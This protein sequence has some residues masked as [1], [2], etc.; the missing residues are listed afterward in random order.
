[1]HTFLTVETVVTVVHDLNSGELG[2]RVGAPFATE[3]TSLQ[4]NSGPYSRPV[5]D[6]KLLNIKN[7]TFYFHTGSPFRRPD[8]GGFKKSGN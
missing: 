5:M 4:K 2:L 6:G 1:M 3:G 8:T 7:D